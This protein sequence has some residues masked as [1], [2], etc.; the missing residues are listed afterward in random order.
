MRVPRGHGIKTIAALEKGESPPALDPSP[1]PNDAA[2][3]LDF[4]PKREPG[5]PFHLSVKDAQLG[6]DGKLHAKVLWRR[7]LLSERET[8]LIRGLFP[9]VGP[10]APPAQEAPKSEG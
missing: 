3:L 7:A 4:N 9:I 5:S 10:P 8:E 2:L 6:A 1:L